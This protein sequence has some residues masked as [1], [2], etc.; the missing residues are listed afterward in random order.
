MD[1]WIYYILIAVIV[2]NAWALLRKYF[3][4]NIMEGLE[5]NEDINP[6]PLKNVPDIING[7]QEAINLNLSNKVYHLNKNY[8]LFYLYLF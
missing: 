5:N 8:F 1:D 3:G 7:H 2:V 6:A 4:K